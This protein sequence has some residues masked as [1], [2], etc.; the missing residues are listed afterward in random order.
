MYIGSVDVFIN[1]DEAL[2]A[3]KCTVVE[4]AEAEVQA[5]LLLRPGG[6][7]Y[8][9]LLPS[10]HSQVAIAYLTR[11]C[12]PFRASAQVL[13]IANVCGSTACAGFYC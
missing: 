11:V 8:G 2:Y 5:G 3:L 6:C 12:A 9:S 4:F 1:D 7:G 13:K 10:P